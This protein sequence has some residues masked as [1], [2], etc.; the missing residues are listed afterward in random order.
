MALHLSKEKD[1]LTRLESISKEMFSKKSRMSFQ[2]CAA[3]GCPYKPKE[4]EKLK[5]IFIH[6]L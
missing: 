3:V 4:K 2:S 1:A 6:L 5:L